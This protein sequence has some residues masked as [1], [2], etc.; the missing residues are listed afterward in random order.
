MSQASRLQIARMGLEVIVRG[1]RAGVSRQVLGD[2]ARIALEMSAEPIE[3]GLARRE[4]DAKH[5][6][7]T[8]ADGM[9]LEDVRAFVYQRDGLICRICGRAIRPGKQVID[10]IRPIY[11]GG[12]NHCD[13][14]RVVHGFCNNSRG[15]HV[16][17]W[18]QTVVLHT[19]EQVRRSLEVSIELGFRDE[20]GDQV[21]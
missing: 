3:T 1:L 14:L 4:Q 7:R 5:K 9:R 8:E 16:N 13:N 19:D 20:F 10:H 12:D 6:R 15:P 2:V 21:R 11:E 18:H 17:H